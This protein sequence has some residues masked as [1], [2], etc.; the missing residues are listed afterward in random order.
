MEGFAVICF[1]AAIFGFGIVTG[2]LN[3]TNDVTQKQILEANNLCKSSEGIY[4]IN[5]GSKQITAYCKNND[6]FTLK[7]DDK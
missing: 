4:K 7:G 3:G 6:K 5:S 2:N 1:L